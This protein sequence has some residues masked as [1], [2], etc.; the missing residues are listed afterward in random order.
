MIER[1]HLAVLT[2]IEQQ[3]TLTQAAESL[4]LSQSALSHS[5]KKLEQQLG[6]P[7]WEKDGRKLRLTR[8][9]K[10]ILLLAKRILPQ[11]EHTEALLKQIAKGQLGTLRI[12]MEC[13]P[14]YQWLLKVVAPYLERWPNV[15]VDVKQAFQ[16]GG[17]RALFDYDIDML[18]TPDPLF[19]SGVEFIP[20]F[21]YEHRLVVA[22]DH[23]LA[24]RAHITPADLADEILITYPVEPQRLDVF[25]QFLSPAG[26]GVK[27]HKRIEATEIMLQMVTA[28]RGVA[29]LPG[30]L[31]EQ[32]AQQMPLTS[33]RFGEQGI[34]KQI[35]VGIR[36]G[37]TKIEY[38][39]DFIRL[40]KQTDAN[41]G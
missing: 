26:C 24:T 7:L 10:Q 3:G 17:M 20:V 38:I 23:P 31:I 30:W 33:L 5:M 36:N 18:I 1:F 14:C 29:A 27:Q 37:D 2:A 19:I 16:F 35:H 40:A 11:F 25:S 41:Y 15:D 9:G 28:G 32:H 39:S 21:A 6:T 22:A 8:A 12:G 34:M 4:H 13:H